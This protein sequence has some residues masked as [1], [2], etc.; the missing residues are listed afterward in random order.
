MEVDHD[1]VATILAGEVQTW[2]ELRTLLKLFTHNFGFLNGSLWDVWTPVELWILLGIILCCLK[3]FWG[4]LIR[5]KV[6]LLINGQTWSV[7]LSLE[8]FSWHHL[9]D[10]S[11]LGISCHVT[12]IFQVHLDLLVV[13][14]KIRLFNLVII[15]LT[16]LTSLPILFGNQI[17]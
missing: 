4:V 2:N 12:L 1:F 5:S 9:V 3:H 10:I 17:W 15:H 7:D 8:S 13:K 16:W 11:S 6:E 14:L